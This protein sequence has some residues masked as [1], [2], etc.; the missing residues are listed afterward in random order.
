MDTTT[1]THRGKFETYD[2]IVKEVL[3]EANS[4]QSF[5]LTIKGSLHKNHYQGSNYVPFTWQDLQEQINHL[6][7]NLC[8]NANEAQIHT[9]EV[10]LNISTPFEVTPFL[11]SS[12]LGKNE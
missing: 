6:S 8:I 2:L 11:T 12:F 7:K 1:T 5:Y 4:K 9:L 10:G 3:N